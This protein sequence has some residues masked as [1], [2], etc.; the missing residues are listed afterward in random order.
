MLLPITHNPAYIYSAVT[1]PNPSALEQ[2]N[3]T[4]YSL[5]ISYKS[6]LVPKNFTCDSN[7]HSFINFSNFFKYFGSS[8]PAIS[9]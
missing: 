3:P 7:P 2:V 8:Q 9:K 4:S 1:L 5:Y 6:F